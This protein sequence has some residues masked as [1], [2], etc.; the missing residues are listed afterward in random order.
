MSF[1]V[2]RALVHAGDKTG[3]DAR[4]WYMIS[5]DAKSLFCDCSAYIHC[6][7][8]QLCVLDKGSTGRSQRG[9]GRDQKGRGSGQRG[10]GR[11]Q[12]LKDEEQMTEDE[13]RKNLEHEYMEEMLLQKE[14]KF[15]V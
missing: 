9:R 1:E 8:A 4:S 7:I 15:E 2:A 10:R 6:H 3:G 12:M 13:I 11:G 14:Q 5:R